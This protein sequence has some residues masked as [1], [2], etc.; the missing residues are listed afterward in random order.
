MSSKL[1]E[2]RMIPRREE[3]E[4]ETAKLRYTNNIAKGGQNEHQS[5]T[6]YTYANMKITIYCS[7]N[8]D[9]VCNVF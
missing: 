2:V 5:E 7:V 4:R 3:E 9:A 6:F 8:R 1:P